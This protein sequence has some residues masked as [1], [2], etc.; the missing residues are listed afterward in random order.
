MYVQWKAKARSPNHCFRGKAISAIYSTCVS[1]ALDI[2]HIKPMRR[3]KLSSV[4]CP[5]LPHF[6]SLSHNGTI[7]GKTLFNI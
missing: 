6:P 4:A 1:V 2:Q 7:I 5:A 3:I